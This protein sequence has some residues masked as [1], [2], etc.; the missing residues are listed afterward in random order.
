MAC[1]PTEEKYG[2]EDSRFEKDVD[3]HF[4]CSICYNVLKEPRMCRNNEHVF[5]LAC[6][7]EHLKVNSHTCPEC[8]EHLSVDTL[9]RP[10]VL[11]NYLSKLKIN[12]D[13]ASRG[14]PEFT[15]LEDLENHVA[16]CG[17]AP[18]FC[19]NENC[20]MKINKQERDHHETVVCEY[21]K[22]Y[23]QDCGQIQEAVGKLE[24]SLIE[25]DG[26][27]E[28]ANETMQS[29][30][31]EMKKVVGKLEGNL[32]ELDG[33]V[34]AA[35]EKMEKNY[36]DMKTIVGKLEG[37]LA[38]MNKRINDKVEAVG[39]MN[40]MVNEKVEAVKNSQDQIKEKVE[41]EVGEVK[42]VV[43]NV[44]QNLSKVNKDVDEV[45]IMMIQM[46]E[47]LNT[48][49][50]LNKL[51]SP[52][53]EILKT[54]REDIL[55][56]GGRA[57]WG[58]K[59]LKSTAIY[60]WE[61]NGWFE[62]S[63]MNEEHAGASSFIYNDQL[64]VVGGGDNKTIETLDLN[65]LPLKCM[66]F[67]GELPY[68][69]GGYQAVV[70]QQ[71]VIHIGGFNYDK[72][73]WSN[74]ISELQLTSPCT[75]KKLCQMP[76]PREYHSAKIIEDKVLVFGGQKSLGHESSLDS[77]LAFDVK[78]NECKEMPPLPH[79]LTQMATVRWRDQVVVLGG[80]DRDGHVLND[81]FMYDCNTGKTKALPSMLEKR[82]RYCAVITGN[83]IVVMGGKNEKEEYLNSVEC[84]A[85]GGSTWEY[86]PD[87]NE[88]RCE[89]IS[90]V[91]PSTRKYV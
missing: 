34:E 5:C 53:V 38:G 11:S 88:A 43:K 24:G 32:V 70:Y 65:E 57:S 55:I 51:P 50:L 58:T 6:I 19:S 46:L 82:Y 56:A 59:P 7:S 4:H 41:K 15:C 36:A 39:E 18:V 9:R 33:K 77:V 71:R 12:C 47:K 74:L 72:R 17:F 13:Y 2:Y 29:N 73:R 91:L 28:A 37:S 90:E 81:V 80:R 83:T 68:G 44:K 42:R 35:N 25:L 20:G 89:A 30:H 21:R 63:P 66:K 16:S 67:P 3:Q 75:M 31:V 60:S 64:F 49:E 8:S 22:M 79:P 85:M 76:E 52:S 48:I 62:V 69:C 84:F 14:C 40:R 26:K 27:V 86:L 23:C 45:K 61:K 1:C 87:M 10:R 54:P 78:K